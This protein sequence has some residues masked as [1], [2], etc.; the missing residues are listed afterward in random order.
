MEIT[1][2]RAPGGCH[3]RRFSHLQGVPNPAKV[4]FLVTVSV[5]SVAGDVGGGQDG[6]Q[7]WWFGLGPPPVV[8]VDG[9]DGL[10]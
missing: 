3:G 1:V 7:W 6:R 8:I 5:R 4:A 9:V 2:L 10:E